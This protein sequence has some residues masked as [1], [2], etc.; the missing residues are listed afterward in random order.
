MI[1]P[2]Q[3]EARVFY[4]TGWDLGN[5]LG[6]GIGNVNSTFNFVLAG[7]TTGAGVFSREDGP[8]T[9]FRGTAD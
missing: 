6:S 2:G 5:R 1:N 9:A 7:P 3:G 4:P 8:G